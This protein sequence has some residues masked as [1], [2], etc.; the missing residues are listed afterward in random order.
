MTLKDLYNEILKTQQDI[1]VTYGRIVSL[2]NDLK[3]KIDTDNKS[4]TIVNRLEDLQNQ[5]DTALNLLEKINKKQSELEQV[6]EVLEDTIKRDESDQP[7]TDER[8]NNLFNNKEEEEN[9]ENVSIES[10]E[11]VKSISADS[12]DTQ[13]KK[14]QFRSS[15][16]SNSS[17][18]SEIEST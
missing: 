7:Q 17:E 18:E 10:E 9:V 5:V 16:S 12:L 11:Q 2:E 6:V 15:Q 4:D 1:A 3:K 14:V 8:Q 13:T